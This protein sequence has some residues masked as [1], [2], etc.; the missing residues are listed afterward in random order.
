MIVLAVLLM[1]FGFIMFFKT[2]WF[3]RLT[4]SW[5][6]EKVSGPSELYDINIK[7]GGVMCFLVG[8]AGVVTELF[9]T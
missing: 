9:F 3:W 2:D 6:S 1:A 8:L 7:F 5:K 4:E